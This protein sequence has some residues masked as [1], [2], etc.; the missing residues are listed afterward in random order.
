MVR[1]KVGFFV[2]DGRVSKELHLPM[3]LNHHKTISFCNLNLLCF[4]RPC[5]SL[6]VKDEISDRETEL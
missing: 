6:V 3:G 2:E 4:H 1:S 5:Q